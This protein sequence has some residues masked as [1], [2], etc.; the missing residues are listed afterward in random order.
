[1]G[2]PLGVGVVVEDEPSSGVSV[3]LKKRGRREGKWRRDWGYLTSRKDV[4]RAQCSSTDDQAVVPMYIAYLYT[5]ECWNSANKT[6][7]YKRG[8]GA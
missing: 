2:F 8:Q 3:H 7:D 6:M 5:F 4:K 1:M